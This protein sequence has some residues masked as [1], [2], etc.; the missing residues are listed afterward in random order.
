MPNFTATSVPAHRKEAPRRRGWA[1]HHSKTGNDK[2]NRAWPRPDLGGF[3]D[4][5]DEDDFVTD[6][7][8]ARGRCRLVALR[9]PRLPGGGPHLSAAV[10][11]PVVAAG[12]MTHAWSESFSAATAYRQKLKQRLYGKLW[13]WFSEW[14][15]LGALTV[16]R[17][18]HRSSLRGRVEGRERLQRCMLCCDG[19]SGTWRRTLSACNDNGKR[20]QNEELKNV[21]TFKDA[22]GQ[23]RGGTN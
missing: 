21:E 17:G 3:G 13:L 15:S 18:R 8:G 22:I 12:L 20:L 7:A 4:G 23:R 19:C 2:C 5:A 9:P 16:E 1:G 6:A 10:P 11:V 14:R